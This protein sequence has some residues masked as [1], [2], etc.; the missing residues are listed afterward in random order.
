MLA[1][2][3]INVEA[4]V[5]LLDKPDKHLDPK[6]CQI[7]MKFVRNVFVK[8]GIQVIMTTHRMDTV[9]LSGD[10]EL[11]VIEKKG[12]DSITHIRPIHK[13]LAMAKLSRNAREF[14]G[15]HVKVYTESFDDSIFYR[16]IYRLI[17]AREEKEPLIAQGR[18]L[19]L[20][21]MPE[22]HSVCFHDKSGGG[23]T[24]I[25]PLIVREHAFYNQSTSFGNSLYPP[26]VLV[27]FA[28]IDDDFGDTSKIVQEELKK[29]CCGGSEQCQELF[30][31]FIFL[32]RHSLENYLYDPFLLS[33][34]ITDDISSRFIRNKDVAAIILKLKEDKTEE[35]LLVDA[36]D[37]FDLMHKSLENL[38]KIDKLQKL[39][40][41]KIVHKE[42]IEINDEQQDKIIKSVKKEMKRY[43]RFIRDHGKD[44]CDKLDNEDLFV[45]LSDFIEEEIRNIVSKGCTS[46]V[47][48]HTKKLKEC[49][50]SNY[51]KIINV[52]LPCQENFRINLIGGGK[53]RYYNYPAWLF[54]ARGHDIESVFSF[55]T[56]DITPKSESITGTDG[57]VCIPSDTHSSPTS[58][59]F[60]GSL[61]AI[62]TVTDR[63][64][65]IPGDLVEVM[66]DLSNKIRREINTVTKKYDPDGDTNTVAVDGR[67]LQKK[68]VDI[69]Q[70]K[71]I[72]TVNGAVDGADV[73]R[74]SI[75]SSIHSLSGAPSLDRAGNGA[76]DKAVGQAVN[77]ASDVSEDF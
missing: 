18:L 72:G 16:S 47:T 29:Y 52:K 51:E 50:R 76:V 60:T 68:W 17:I 37:F 23:K 20:R 44:V 38:R 7:F 45:T 8:N 28:L 35:E 31:R 11:F 66:N 54:N 39:I 57:D 70:K 33:S 53:L 46:H 22:F 26:I 34:I 14:M 59:S 56:D 58:T 61:L 40:Y 21:W 62:L 32:K 24:V 4:K 36:N 19:S 15:F 27:P 63:D 5:M 25:P 49:H 13:M 55:I 10:G 2:K 77:E 71:G 42:V 64:V 30:E 74:S 48:I 73:I 41:A 12:I 67:L 6:L 3:N 1:R 65:C 69:V 75:Y 9:A 43:N